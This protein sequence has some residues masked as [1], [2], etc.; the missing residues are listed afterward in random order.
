MFGVTYS[1]VW[2]F[3]DFCVVI[4][5]SWNL[6]I[7]LCEQPA[8]LSTCKCACHGP[9][10][11][12]SRLWRCRG[13]K[14]Y[15]LI[16]WVLLKFCCDPCLGLVIS[17]FLRKKSSRNNCAT[18]FTCSVSLKDSV[19]NQTCVSTWLLESRYRLLG[20]PGTGQPAHWFWHLCHGMS[21]LGSK[22][23]KNHMGD[24]KGEGM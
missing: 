15:T 21:F 12:Y 10:M 9:W 5:V 13:D 16:C 14:L 8:L 6:E 24:L 23:V 11:L 7:S 19:V 4:T 2:V 1:W 17:L 18:L 22:N 3:W 20:C